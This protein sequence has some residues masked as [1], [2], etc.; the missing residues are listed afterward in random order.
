MI[1]LVEE[2][3]YSED[4]YQNYIKNSELLSFYK[5]DF[6]IS[7]KVLCGVENSLQRSQNI[8]AEDKKILFN[9][10]VQLRNKINKREQEI[11]K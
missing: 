10:I 9:Q 7:K 3:Y 5:L 6:P 11:K 4:G 2:I 1:T 8:D